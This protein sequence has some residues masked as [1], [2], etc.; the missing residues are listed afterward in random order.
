MTEKVKELIDQKRKSIRFLIWIGIGL[1][2]VF[3]I[4]LGLAESEKVDNFISMLAT[5]VA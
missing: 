5:L 4:A 1:P 3:S 2:T